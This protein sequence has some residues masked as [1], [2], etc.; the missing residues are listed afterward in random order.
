M[1]KAF[2]ADGLGVLVGWSKMCIDFLHLSLRRAYRQD[3]GL[4]F[5]LDF[6]AGMS[7]GNLDGC[8]FSSCDVA[9]ESTS[10]MLPTRHPYR[11]LKIEKYRGP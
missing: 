8:V 10:T 9:L 4:L 2:C 6:G 11:N 1:N 5:G 7:R 3:P